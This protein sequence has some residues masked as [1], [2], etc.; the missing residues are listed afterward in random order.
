VVH[1]LAKPW[2]VWRPWQLVHRALVLVKSPRS[3]FGSLP[4]AWGTSLWANPAKT[5]G[6]SIL[7]TGVYDLAVTEVLGRL[8]SPGDTVIDAGANVGYM[9]VL[10]GIAAGKTG[11]VVSWEPHPE[12]F[13][14]LQRNVAAL[15]ESTGITS[16]STRNAALGSES[17]H[18]HLVVP[19]GM[20]WNDGLSYVGQSADGT[21][22]RIL[23]ETIDDVIEDAHVAVLKLDVEGT[24][25]A[26]LRGASCALAQRRIRHIVFED[27]IG[28]DS[29]VMRLLAAYGY[30]IFSLGWSMRGVRLS[31]RVSERL[32][33]VYE[34]PSYVATLA[35]EEV[36]A[37]CST[38]GW[39][40]LSAKFNRRSGAAPRIDRATA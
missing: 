12:L 9:T 36:F 8:I 15:H 37:R 5:I 6:R 19:P 38:L 32:A 35:A 13:R 7:T 23:V 30:R 34:A 40:T 33:A 27:H 16:I 17:A 24:E 14:V 10:A 21:S 29:D 25:A 28:A 22:V 4:V 3:E 39:L 31:D 2:Y 1:Q 11:R 18:A 26:V 20:S